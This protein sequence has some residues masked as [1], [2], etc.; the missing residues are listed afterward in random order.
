M[1]VKIYKQTIEEVDKTFFAHDALWEASRIDG[2]TVEDLVEVTYKGADFFITTKIDDVDA[3]ITAC[4]H[5]SEGCV[6]VHTFV[7]PRYRGESD[8]ILESHML[9]LEALGYKSIYTVCSS[10]NKIV[11]NFLEKRLGFETYAEFTCGLLKV[12]GVMPVVYRLVKTL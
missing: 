5:L 7:L 1:S 4:T 2:K 6:E 10:R 3:C 9:S 11:K 12:D 8:S